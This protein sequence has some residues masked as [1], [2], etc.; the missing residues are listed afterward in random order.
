M[1]KH[2]FQTEVN[3][4]LHLIIH[5]LYS[6]KEIFLR[7]LVSNASDALDKLKYLTVSDDAYKSIAF[8]PSIDITL[9]EKAH[10]LIIQD[11]G[12]GMNS[13]DLVQNLG[14]IARSGTKAFMQSLSGES[15][16][17][18]N[19]IGQFGVGF[20]SAFMVADKIEVISRKV[21]EEKAWKWTSDGKGSYE[22]AEGE[23]DKNGTRITLYL[24]EEGKQYSQSWEVKSII[25]KYSDHVA[26]PITMHFVRKD[27]KDGKESES[28]ADE[29]VN[30]ASAL[31]KRNKSEIPDED[32]K[33]FYK[34]ISGDWNE[35][36][37]WFHTRAEGTQEYVTLFYIP[38]QAPFDLY[39]ADY[40]PGV[41]LYVR[42]VF[43]TDDDKELLP[44]YLRFVRGVIDSE[45]LPLNVSREIL[46]QNKILASIRT[47]SVKKILGEIENMA[48]NQPELFTKFINIFNRPMKE[49]LYQ[50]FQN[51]DQLLDLV[52]FHSTHAEG[53]VSLKEY[54]DRMKSEQ[55]AIY[56]LSGG[57]LA[58]LKKSPLL[59]AY[60]K[61]DME[62]LLLDEDLDEII[63]PTLNKYKDLDIKSINKVETA[64][65]L[66]GE[67][68]DKKTE[69]DF[70]PVIKR[71]KEA[72]GD[73][74]KDVISSIRLTDSPSC[75]VTSEEDPTLQMQKM[76]KAMGQ[77]GEEVKPI[78]EVNP[79]HP[80]LLALKD[81]TDSQLWLDT[82]TLLLEQ[83]L[84]LEGMAPSDAGSL[85]ESL[86][87]MLKKSLS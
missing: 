81:Q 22:L 70:Q 57:T 64:K 46:Q 42:R 68:S 31:W 50:D 85:A 36:L 74:V 11:N 82:S 6:H 25:K 58:S 54:K 9:D 73:K 24:N 52:R 28:N 20:Y 66:G 45:D 79:N 38:S 12:I 86:N 67:E 87:R 71:I 65:D 84:L 63:L 34:T 19:L 72:L 29:Q 44:T 15:R 4:L 21:L 49:G 13:E 76:M 27:Y 14:T 75:I 48:A 51:K 35:P 17:D 32:Y 10:T 23:L 3:Q 56:V 55:K 61:R 59:E 83:A 16:K 5:S 43:I 7:E 47:A 41:K 40:K 53:W 78:L 77:G 37:T 26:F 30:N 69:E 18:S 33:E 39:N 80:I 2:E 62:V 8:T 1:A 60:K